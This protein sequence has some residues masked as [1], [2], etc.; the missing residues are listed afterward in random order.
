MS[1]KLI[2]RKTNSPFSGQYADINQ[3]S[4]LSHAQLDGNFIYLKGHMIYSGSTDGSILKLHKLNN[5]SV[6]VDLS[7]LIESGD[8]YLTGGT[9]TASAGTITFI[10]NT[11]G[12]FSVSGI[13]FED[14]YVTG[15]TYDY[16]SGITTFTNNLGGTFLVT[17]FTD[18]YV[19][20]GTYN[21]TG[22][23]ITFTNNLG[24]DFQVNGLE[25][26]GNTS[27][28]C[29]TDIFVSN[30]YGCSPV[31]FH[32]GIQS[33]SATTGEI[34]SISF[35][36]NTIA[37][38]SELVD[39][40]ITVNVLSA[41]TFTTS[42]P[43]YSL[44]AIVLSGDVSNE[45][46][47][48]IWDFCSEFIIS[49]NSGTEIINS[50]C[51][52]YDIYYDSGF[53][54]IVDGN[55][56]GSGYTLISGTSSTYLPTIMTR[57]SYA[58]GLDT[59]ASGITSHAEGAYSTAGGNYSHAEGNGSRAL[60]SSAHAEGASTLATGSEAHAEGNNTT[61][62]G[63]FSH[64]EGWNSIAS[65]QTSHAEGQ[66]TRAGGSMSHAEGFNTTANNAYA[67]AQGFGTIASGIGSHSEGGSTRATGQYSHAEGQSTTA[68][69]LG[70]HA[71]GGSNIA[72]A[73]YSHAEG[74]GTSASGIASHAEGANTNASGWFS[75]AEGSSS[76][77]IGSSAHAEGTSTTASGNYSHAEGWLTTASSN[78]SHAEGY[79][80]IASAQGAHAEGGASDFGATY[81]GGTASNRAAHAEGIRTTASGLASHAEGWQSKATG[82]YTHAEGASTTASGSQSHAEG[83]N[84]VAS[85]SSSHAEGNFTLASGTVSHAEG[86]YTT[87]SGFMAHGE[88]AQTISS[89]QASHSEGNL[90]TAS[91]NQ[92]HSEG[93]LTIAS[94][95]SAHAEGSVTRAGGQAAHAEGL[96]TIA[97]GAG[98]HAE[99]SQT[100]AS[101]EHSHAEGSLTTAS[102]TQSHA[103]GNYTLASG[104]FSHTSGAG[105]NDKT[106]GVKLLL[107]AGDTSFAH[108]KITTSTI[109]RGAQGDY[110]VI[111]GGTNHNINLGAHYSGL[112]V[113]NRNA[114]NS[115]IL[116]SAVIGG[117]LITGVTNDTVY[118]PYLNLNYVPANDNAL[119]QVLV[120]A[121]D[122]TVKYKSVSSF[123]D[124]TVT[125]GTYDANTGIVTFTNNSGGTFQVTGFTSG[126]T[127]SYTT[128]AYTV[129][130]E[131]RF[132]NNIQG[133][134]FYNVDLTP[135]V[136]SGNTNFAN[137][138]LILNNSRTH[139]LNGFDL[140]IGEGS[141]QTI[142]MFNGFA[143]QITYA[144]SIWEI[145][146][147]YQDFSVSGITS[148][149]LLPTE[150]VFNNN[151]N[152]YNF[153]VEGDSDQNL[154]FT[155]A[156][157]DRVG[158]GTNTPTEKLHVSGNTKISGTLSIG[159][160]GTGTS[161][162]TL[163]I[164]S[165]GFVV[166]ATTSVGVTKYAA[167]VPMT[168]ATIETVTHSLGTT[169]VTVQL[170]DSTGK[171]IIPDVVNNY[172]LN[173]VDIK[174]SSTETYRV[175]IIG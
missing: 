79:K 84:V 25:F 121:S 56:T 171:L 76:T 24:G 165:N 117:Q 44:P 93:F 86:S 164:D 158:I 102:G 135:I 85:G 130:N 66:S 175:I 156:S 5:T 62:S 173:S 43:S 167:S 28:N 174:V 51:S 38:A 141:A 31:T 101:G 69:A 96:S 16:N 20:G 148:L 11:G 45:W 13:S 64:S 36:E 63:L 71:E 61:A 98:A 99:G 53:T 143:T 39:V 128:T 21:Y 113:G 124:M 1:N 146:S 118:V 116:R 109:N 140:V 125:G 119:T 166:T 33:Q 12:T 52:S 58:Y 65:G 168:G 123:T 133:S 23:T 122:G 15:G 139:D 49:G 120:R 18:T 90:T 42:D 106:L 160:L 10:N 104:N 73:N 2:L 108:F 126:M 4:V 151:G 27:A 35:G 137:T 129:G 105:Y 57:P 59:I 157:T 89:G 48:Y 112:F 153:R 40:I 154:L 68:S 95:T 8:T 72:N 169:D 74:N 155:K 32:N 91:G 30:V 132:D 82:D 3:G 6:D 97:S 88:G 80:S 41:C 147:N 9:Y 78:Y 159:T 92:S 150:A 94:G 161:I 81:T 50:G 55:L 70:S 149:S 114:I 37:N 110:S 22:G 100:T 134:N 83:T 162:N 103:S 67:H 136:T 60:G 172:T 131:I 77:S 34:N 14:T 7:T 17:G 138:D 54:Y 107:A 29:I 111:L 170:K 46:S 163:G 19:T 87:A 152:N 47:V 144:N 115:D 142:A 127:D 26:T 75:H 145:A